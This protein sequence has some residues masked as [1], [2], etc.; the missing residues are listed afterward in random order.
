M[1]EI[2]CVMAACFGASKAIEILIKRLDAHV[3]KRMRQHRKEQVMKID[4]GKITLYHDEI[5]AIER[6]C[7]ILLRIEKIT[8]QDTSEVVNFLNQIAINCHE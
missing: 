2:L 3:S 1:L 5:Q 8:Q 6:T 4:N 7:E